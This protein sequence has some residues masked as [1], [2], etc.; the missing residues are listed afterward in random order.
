MF[1]NICIHV[2]I[3]YKYT[4]ICSNLK[5]NILK[6]IMVLGTGNLEKEIKLLSNYHYNQN[7]SFKPRQ[8]TRP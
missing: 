1:Q 6:D 2:C 3:I 5:E 7:L 8:R 4:S